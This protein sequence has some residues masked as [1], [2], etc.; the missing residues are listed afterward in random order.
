MRLPMTAMIVM[1]D[2]SCV[3]T[4]TVAAAVA[5]SPTLAPTRESP[6]IAGIRWRPPAA[7]L[8]AAASKSLVLIQGCLHPR[9]GKETACH[10]HGVAKAA[11]E[12]VAQ[13]VVPWP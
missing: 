11:E 13:P 3:A 4:E 6:R 9:A 12:G 7:V 8:A 5:V 2:V 10:P 1:H